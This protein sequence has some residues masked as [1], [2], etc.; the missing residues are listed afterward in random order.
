FTFF[1]LDP[2]FG[3]E[4]QQHD[5]RLQEGVNAQYLRPY[6]IFGRQALI[7]TGA[8]LHASQ[9]AVGLFPAVARVP[10]RLG[11]NQ[12]LGIDTPDVLLT[13]AHAAVTN[14]AGYIQQSLNLLG[15]HLRLE[16]GMRF[17]YFRF[18]VSDG[19]NRTPTKT[20]FFSGSE[21]AGRF[22]PKAAVAYTISDRLP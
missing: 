6:Q 4:I 13:K 11:A 10:N 7:T 1:L 19:V 9:I 5:S 20:S 16:G 21:G 14:T 8:N 17:D 22:Q 18:N 12:A 3:D 2:E 15:G